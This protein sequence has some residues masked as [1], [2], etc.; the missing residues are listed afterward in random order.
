VREGCPLTY[1]ATVAKINH[2]AIHTI[3]YSVMK[4]AIIVSIQNTKHQVSLNDSEMVYYTVI[5]Q[6]TANNLC[7]TDVLRISV[8]HLNPG[9]GL[10]SRR[11]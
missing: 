8:G 11:L 9:R 6:P 2:T 7:E 1:I 5:I 3:E 10:K 4:F